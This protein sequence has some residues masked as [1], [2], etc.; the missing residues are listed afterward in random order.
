MKIIF[1]RRKKIENVVPLHRS[2][3][4][5]NGNWP[6]STVNWESR[7]ST[8][9]TFGNNRRSYAIN[10]LRNEFNLPNLAQLTINISPAGS[11][12]ID[13]N[14]V[15]VDDDSWSGYYFPGVPVKVKANQN[16]GYIFSHWLEFPDSNDVMQIYIT[17]PST[18]TAV[19][20]PTE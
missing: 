7:L 14:T 20:Y 10:H 4:Y 19:F 11:G 18:L 3:W 1:E 6:N 9:E 12:T 15:N 5:N 16:N 2:K 17:N 8:M 13:L